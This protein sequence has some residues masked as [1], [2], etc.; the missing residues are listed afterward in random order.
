MPMDHQ[1]R[2]GVFTPGKQ[3]RYK[4]TWHKYLKNTTFGESVTSLNF[5]SPKFFAIHDKENKMLPYT[6]YDMVTFLFCIYESQNP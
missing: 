6:Q 4:D 2:F 3:W 1:S 5:H